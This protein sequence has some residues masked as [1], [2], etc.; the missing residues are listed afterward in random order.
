MELILMVAVFGFLIWWMSRS[1]KKQRLAQ[2]EA[3]DA[4]L[5]VGANVRTIGG[6]FGTV[7]DIDG[8]AITLESPSGVETVWFRGAIQGPAELPLASTMPD[9]GTESD[10]G[11]GLETGEPVDVTDP[12]QDDSPSVSTLEDPIEKRDRD[13]A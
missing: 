10:L 5:V 13:D 8:D 4:A 11:S 12:A 1:A 7:V 3:R 6:F 9:Y 2:E